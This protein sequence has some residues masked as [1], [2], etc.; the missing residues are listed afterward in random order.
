MI[1]IET[2]SN[3]K[4]VLDNISK[5]LLNKKLTACVHM[6]EMDSNYLWK[7]TLV[8]EKEYKISIKT[9]EKN[10]GKISKLIKRN[11]NYDI[12]ELSI[13]KIQ[14]LNSEYLEWF[15]KEIT[16]NGI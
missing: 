16:S 13:K 14:N 4:K 3:S 10:K 5:K 12:Y 7:D 1:L 9:V 8:K 6:I 11:H 2:T 15:K